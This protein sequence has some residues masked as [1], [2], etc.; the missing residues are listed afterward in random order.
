MKSI[1]NKWKV[2]ILKINSF[3]TIPSVNIDQ[4]NEASQYSAQINRFQGLKMA[5][6]EFPISSP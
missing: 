6:I 3:C 2:E 1:E 5:K 4:I